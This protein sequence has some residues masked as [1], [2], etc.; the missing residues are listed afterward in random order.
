MQTLTPPLL[1]GEDKLL[2]AINAWH[3]PMADSFMY[4]ISNV[5]AWLP[6]VLVLLYYIFYRKPWQEA[7]LLLVCIGLCVLIGD[8]LSSGF[9]KPYFAR[10][11]PTHWEGLR[12]S[13]HIVF[14][15]R[16]R[17]FGF[18]SGHATNFFA[19]AM[20]L[21]RLIRQR[22]VSVLLFSLVA[23]VAYSRMYMGVHFFS[24]ILTGT[25][26]GLII[27]YGASRLYEYLR[28]RLSPEGNASVAQVYAR[29]VQMLLVALIAFLPIL[30]AYSWQSARI[31]KMLGYCG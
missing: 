2:S 3:S 1:P 24:D 26:I 12:D 29:G 11:R 17:E 8:R 9:A 4:M 30:L 15:Y 20:L 7:V 5:G 19:V 18:F 14:G 25:V 28:Q 6:V 31:L 21:S 13:L 10:P 16:G 27:G 22:L 23:L